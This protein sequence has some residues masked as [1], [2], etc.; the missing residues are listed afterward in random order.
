MNQRIRTLEV[1]DLGEVFERAQRQGKNLGESLDHVGA[2]L[3]ASRLDQIRADALDDLADM[4][5]GSDLS[6]WRGDMTI[7]SPQD[8]KHAITARIRLLAKA[9]RTRRQM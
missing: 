5:E 6:E 9:T 8:A 1:N 2:L 7:R 4:L 3:T